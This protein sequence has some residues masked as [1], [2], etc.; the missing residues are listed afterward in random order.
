VPGEQPDPT[1]VTAPEPW[2]VRGPLSIGEPSP[3]V[4]AV[5]A[6]EDPYR[7]DTIADGG[8]ALGMTV[9]AASVRG[10]AK[11][12]AGGPR[13]DDM[14]L[15]VH[16]AAGALIVAVADGVSAA[17]R[18]GV[19][20]ALAVRYAVAAVARQLDDVDGD[21]D[22]DGDRVAA[23]AWGDVFEQARWALVEEHRRFSGEPAA[24]VEAASELLATTL[25]VACVRA[26]EVELA[27]V[28][29]SPAYLLRD[30]EFE[31][32]VGS[33]EHGDGLV[34]GG[35]ASLPRYGGEPGTAVCGLEPGEVLLLCSDGLS[36]PLADG[37]GEVGRTQP[38]APAATRCRR[39]CPATRLQ[40]LEL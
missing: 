37:R 18:S 40:P 1:A 11:R 38:G 21:G 2:L 28:G 20:A 12:F 31:P 39:L 10:L 6:S 5:L 9:R 19:G 26:G 16:S 36:M 17:D 32:L 15:R 33:A 34:G 22:R 30:G 23:V 8:V 24:G 14:C 7:P 27:A 35:V 3:P 4:V 29:D 25:V 13:Q